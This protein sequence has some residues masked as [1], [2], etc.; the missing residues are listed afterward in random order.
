M[1]AILANSSSRIPM[2]TPVFEGQLIAIAIARQAKGPMESVPQARVVV[3]A[4]IEGDRY[5]AGQGAAQFQGRRRPEN[6]VTL[7]A[8][9]AIEAA[10][11]AFDLQI[12]HLHTR[13]NLLTQGV[14]LNELLGC[15]FAV[16]PVVLR[17]LERCEPCGYLE[18]RTYPGIKA[19]LAGRGGLRCA[20]VT[21]GEI[22]L[23]DRIRPVQDTMK[24]R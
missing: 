9:E 10:S 8:R 24:Q 11:A 17:G 13:R 16:G 7:I 2:K 22:Q 12:E 6:E 5:G 3:G 19:A 21:G 1:F 18:K 15:T 14:P 20:V 4:G 23:G